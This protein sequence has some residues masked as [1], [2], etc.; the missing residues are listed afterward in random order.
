MPIN[1]GRSLGEKPMGQKKKM[2]IIT[3]I[4]FAGFIVVWSFTSIQGSQRTYEV[5]PQITLP[6]YRNDTDRALDAYERL[7]ERYMD[8]VEKNLKDIDVDIKKTATKIDFIDVRLK[9]LCE[10]MARIEK[11]L[12]IVQ[13]NEAI[14]GP[15]INERA[16]RVNKIERKSEN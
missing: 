6:G 8:L 3:A 10:R 9:E 15:L 4:I 5:Q 14:Q 11:A 16:G 2:L 1:K 12:G 13:P 7:M